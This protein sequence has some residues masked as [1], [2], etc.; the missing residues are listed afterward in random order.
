MKILTRLSNK[1]THRKDF[2][3]SIVE[4]EQLRDSQDLT[5]YQKI[6]TYTG[7]GMFSDI[8]AKQ[9]ESEINRLTDLVKSIKPA[10]IVEIG[11]YRGGTLFIWRQV[12]T[13]K[14]HIIALDLDTNSLDGEFSKSRRQLYA[15][16]ARQ[17]QQISFIA[18]DSHDKH[19]KERL[20]HTLAGKPIDFL[21]IDGDHTLQGV[22]SDFEMYAPLVRKGGIIAFHDI[23]PRDLPHVKVDQF[24]NQIK[25]QYKH[26][27]YIA[28]D[29]PHARQIGIGVIWKD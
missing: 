8:S 15:H 6:I 10:T 20:Q 1:L 11:T 22:K 14:A 26:Q 16:F 23:L 28:Q 3:R 7:K 18:G 12:A 13:P 5:P 29:G 2:T 9:V 19:T 27:E 17:D 21:F 4:I 24:W 25:S